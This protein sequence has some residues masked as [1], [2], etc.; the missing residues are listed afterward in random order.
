MIDD[1]LAARLG[2][3]LTASNHFS[4]FIIH[5][6][7][8]NNRA[9]PFFISEADYPGLERY[10]FTVGFFF[11]GVALIFVSWRL[12]QVNKSPHKMVLDASVNA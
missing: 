9:F 12:F 3:S 6:I 1:K 10:I 5:L 7:S 8:G 2:W 4:F 11:T